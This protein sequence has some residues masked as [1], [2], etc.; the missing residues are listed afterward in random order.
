MTP[1]DGNLAE[2][3]ELLGNVAGEQ[4][5]NQRKLARRI[6]ISVGLVNALV[7]RMPNIR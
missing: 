5:L 7:A 4:A 6:G 2:R 3:V 1:R